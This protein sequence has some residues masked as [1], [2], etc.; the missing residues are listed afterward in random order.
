MY[1]TFNRVYRVIGDLSIPRMTWRCKMKLVYTLVLLQSAGKSVNR[2]FQP[3]TTK[4]GSWLVRYLGLAK[5]RMNQIG[6]SH[7]M[8]QQY[9][10]NF[11]FWHF[12]QNPYSE[13]WVHKWVRVA[14]PYSEIRVHEQVRDG[15]VYLFMYSNCSEKCISWIFVLFFENGHD[16][17]PPHWNWQEPMTPSS[18]C[19]LHTDDIWHSCLKHLRHHLIIWN[20]LYQWAGPAE[21]L[22]IVGFCPHLL[23]TDP[24]RWV[25]S[26][27]FGIPF[28]YQFNSRIGVFDFFFLK[29]RYTH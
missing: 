11:F 5:I 15:N 27:P 14:I 19:A 28:V 24:L 7:H 10:A 2:K 23:F 20:F 25:S 21:P 12:R 8:S 17:K 9:W 1:G 16:W 13:I 3:F 29:K 18:H 26:T 6:S 22:G 4:L